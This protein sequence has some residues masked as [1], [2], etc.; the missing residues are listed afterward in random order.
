MLVPLAQGR[1]LLL[2]SIAL[3][4][5]AM[6]VPGMAQQQPE[7]T[8]AQAHSGQS[9]ASEPGGEVVTI[10]PH[11]QNARWWLSGQTNTI[12][13]AHPDFHA[14]YSGPNS[15]HAQGESKTSTVETLYLGY[16]LLRGRRC[17]W[18]LNPQAG[19]L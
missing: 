11:P 15:L 12:F 1:I 8:T 14:A 3:L 9:S 17:C 6:P 16:Q 4:L 18:T 7:S 5:C 2:A 19:G 10:V 13:Q